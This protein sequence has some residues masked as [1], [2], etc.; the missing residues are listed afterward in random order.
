MKKVIRK[1]HLNDLCSLTFRLL[2][3]RE[4][5]ICFLKVIAAEQLN[6][7]KNVTNQN[8]EEKVFVIAMQMLKSFH[9]SSFCI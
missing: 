7:T 5:K 3:R 8:F 1:K 9:R 4:V 2:D 6:S